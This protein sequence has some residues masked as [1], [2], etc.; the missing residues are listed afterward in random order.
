MTTPSF[1]LDPIKKLTKDLKNASITLSVKEVR[2]LVNSYY[3]IQEYRKAA[4]N[5][6]LALDKDAHPHEVISWLNENMNSLE[7]QI[8]RALDAWSTGQELGVW[9]KSIVGIGPVI[10]SGLMAHIDIEKAPTAGHIWSFA[11][12]YGPAI[13]FEGE[14][15]GTVIEWKK[16]EKRPWNADLKTLCWKIGESFVK[17]CNNEKDIY[18]KIYLER[19]ELEIHRN[20]KL[21]FANQAKA[22][23]EKFKIG[24]DTDAY[25]AYIIGKL[26]P[27]HIQ[28]R[29]KRKAVMMFLSH[30]HHVYFCMYYKKLPPKPFIIE[31]GGHAHVIDPPNFNTKEYL[32][33]HGVTI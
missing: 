17:V 4:S 8:K 24:K 3:Q 14:I 10:A 12:M 22:K 30:F 18:G 21:M 19:K 16:G 31:H 23:L 27:A 1:E 15:P 29:S 9:C 28:S 25:K 11:G 2:Y 26:P 7:N 5:Q 13:H 32:A 33:K 6:V 20:D